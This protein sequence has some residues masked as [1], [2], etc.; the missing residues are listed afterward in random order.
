MF[1]LADARPE[2]DNG[3]DL[4]SDF[5]PPMTTKEVPCDS[6]EKDCSDDWGVPRSKKQ[7]DRIILRDG[8]AQRM[9]END[10]DDNGD[11][12]PQC[13]PGEIHCAP[14]LGGGCCPSSH[15]V[16]C[17]NGSTCQTFGPC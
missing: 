3:A 6:T 13:L 14:G 9:E 17:G 4:P 15:P 11:D 7:D 16:C 12:K 10:D 8:K 5:H 2:M 1:A